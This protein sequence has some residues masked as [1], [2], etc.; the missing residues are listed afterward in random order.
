[1]N[2]S[3]VGL[4]RLGLPWACTLAECGFDV[5]G[6][7]LNS[8]IVNAV[9]AGQCIWREPLVPEILREYGGRS[10]RA[11]TEHAPAIADTDVTF[12]LVGTPSDQR[13]RFSNLYVKDALLSLGEALRESE[14]PYHLFV[15]SSTVMPRSMG[16]VCKPLL[17]EAS[18]RQA[19][20]GFGLVYN[21]ET[22]ALGNVVQGYLHPDV[23]LIGA[24]HSWDGDTVEIIHHTVCGG[25]VPAFVRLNW[26]SAELAKV[27]LNAY[28][29]TK[30]S[31][32]NQ[33]GRLCEALPGADVDAITSG[34]GK[35]KRI[36]TAYF[37]AG[38]SFGGTCFP[39][40]VQAWIRLAM[41][42][43]LA[44]PIV[45]GVE[46]VN[47]EVL[48]HLAATVIHEALQYPEDERG[49]G[50]LGYAFKPGTPEIE[51]S[52]AVYLA[53]VLLDGMSV[54]VW[55]PL[56]SDPV[57]VQ[58]VE[59]NKALSQRVVVV[60]HFDRQVAEAVEGFPFEKPT[61]V[62]DPWRQL[63]RG[64]LPGCVKYVGMGVG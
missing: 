22:V 35:D 24:E 13:G 53:D 3:V 50:I 37:R 6:V 62:I 39:R 51:A 11:T 2:I 18:G 27:A 61:T 12:I 36:G 56:V 49:V 1:M 9:N 47:R 63:A 34:I 21:P 19:G 20:E 15:V 40:D 4:G 16:E 29:T 60:M 43:G 59:I 30:I 28:V 5:L 14:K 17:E 23:V 41:E 44:S 42:C 64:K 55:D 31:F 33:L 26:I 25:N 46:Q 57:G 8:E 54:V 32:A 58:R 38:T 52:P 48:T 10:L 7:D 45:S